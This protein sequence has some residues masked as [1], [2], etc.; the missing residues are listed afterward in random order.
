MTGSTD[1]LNGKKIAFLTSQVGVEKA[2]LV[3]PW[4]A[5][6]DAH[7]ARGVAGAVDGR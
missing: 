4:Q 1:A 2:E 3:S 5:V 6:A 7:R